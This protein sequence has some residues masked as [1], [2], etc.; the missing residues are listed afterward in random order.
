M[1]AAEAR[2]ALALCAALG[3]AEKAED[4]APV[5]SASP[6]GPGRLAISFSMDE[7]YIPV[8]EEAPAGL[9]QGSIYAEADASAVGPVEGSSSLLDF[10]AGPMDLSGEGGP[11]D[12][13]YTSEELEPQVVWVLGCLDSDASGVCDAGDPITIPN[14]NKV[15]VEAGVTVAFEVYLGMLNP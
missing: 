9:F 2:A 10:V 4:S 14:E 8:M 12:P 11:T 5:D 7:D 1:F 3:C 6:S 15:I 13:L